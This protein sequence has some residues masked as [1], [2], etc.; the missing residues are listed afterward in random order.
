MRAL[1]T[2]PKDD[3]GPTAAALRAVGIDPVIE[4]LFEVVYRRD[5]PLSLNGVQA[6]LLTS[7]NG[8]RALADATDRR[9]LAI[10]AVGESTAELARESG[11]THVESA[12]GDVAALDVLAGAKLN[13]ASGRL[14]HVAGTT[15]AGDLAEALRQRGFDVTRDVLYEARPVGALSENLRDLLANSAIDMALFFSPRTAATFAELVTRAGLA[16]ACG[17]IDA[18]CMSEA[19]AHKLVDLTMHTI[20]I[21]ERPDMTSMIAAAK[22]RAAQ[23]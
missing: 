12:A 18:I 19:V 21:A 16:K 17:S 7:R 1:I 8:A 10:F 22:M 4:P 2:R 9:D 5:T 13:P 20:S 14:V 11:F 6:V 23:R 3:A 15:V